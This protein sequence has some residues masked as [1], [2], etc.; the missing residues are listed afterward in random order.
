MFVEMPGH[1][2]GDSVDVKVT[3]LKR[4]PSC[5]LPNANGGAS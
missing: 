4:T 3:A 5:F 1:E 2:M